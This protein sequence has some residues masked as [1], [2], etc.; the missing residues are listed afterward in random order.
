MKRVTI[1][2]IAREAGVSPGAVSFALNDRPGV[3]E[4]TRERIKQVAVELGW[5]RSAAAA[6]LSGKRVGSFGLTLQRGVGDDH[7]EAFI[8]RFMAGMQR[9]LDKNHLSIVLQVVPSI[10]AEERTLRTWWAERRVDGVVLLRPTIDDSRARVLTEIGM[11]GV[12]IGGPV[13]EKI[14][15]VG[16]EEVGTTQLLVD[17]FA[18]RGHQR[19]AYVTGPPEL[20]YVSWR[21]EAFKA[22]ARHHGMIPQVVH[23]VTGDELTGM[24]ASERL[25][26]SGNAPTALLYDNELMTVGGFTACTDAGLTVGTDVCIASFEDSPA[27]RMMRPG[28][29]ALRRHTEQ[30]GALAARSLVNLLEDGEPTSQIGPFPELAVRGSSGEILG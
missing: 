26:R 18:A 24:D 15:T 7:A 11:P 20:Q 1:K 10:E 4:S 23:V 28:I 21:A 22:R 6:A 5:T 14:S 30:I 12:T 9:E 29:S 8:M 17:H 16:V 25:V 27:L 2:D 3:S 13:A 19:T